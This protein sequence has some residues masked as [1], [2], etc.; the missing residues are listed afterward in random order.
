[1][2]VPHVLELKTTKVKV[3]S[4]IIGYDELRAWRRP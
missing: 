2:L 4:E 3:Y 1:M